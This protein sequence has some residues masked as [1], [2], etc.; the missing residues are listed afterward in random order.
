MRRGWLGRELLNDRTETSR[1]QLWLISRI[2]KSATTVLAIYCC[3]YGLI[4]FVDELL[5][6]LEDS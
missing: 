5:D 6:V 1:K 2:E 3:R 4:G